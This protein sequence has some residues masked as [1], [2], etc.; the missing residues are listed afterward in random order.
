MVVDLWDASEIKAL[1]RR[2]GVSQQVLAE[3]IGCSVR[4][5]TAWESGE[6]LPNAI[7][8]ARL[9]EINRGD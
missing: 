5:V 7:H 2:L 3:R 8:Q 1:R 9:H 4:A 6:K